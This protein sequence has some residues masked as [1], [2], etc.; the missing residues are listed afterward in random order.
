MFK[1]LFGGGKKDKKKSKV[2]VEEAIQNLD[3][4]IK[5]MELLLNNYE[6][7]TNALQQEAKAKLRAG[8]KA[9]AKRILAKKKR[10]VD[11]IKTT[12]GALMMME[13]Q[14]GMLEN[15]ETVKSTIET[16]KTAGQVIK[17]NQVNVEELD[18]IKDD[19]DE[20]KA[21]GDEIKDFFSDIVDQ[22]EAD[23]EDDLKALEA[24][25]Q[26]DANKELPSAVKTEITG[27]E[28]KNEERDLVPRIDVVIG[29]VH[30]ETGTESEVEAQLKGA[31]PLGFQGQR[32][33]G[34]RQGG[35]Q[36][37]AERPS[38]VGIG[39]LIGLGVAGSL[40]PRGSQFQEV[41]RTPVPVLEGRSRH[42]AQGGRR[43]EV[44][45][46]GDGQRRRPVVASRDVQKHPVAVAQVKEG[47][48]RVHLFF[49]LRLAKDAFRG[50]GVVVDGVEVGVGPSARG[51]VDA[52]AVAVVLL[53]AER[54]THVK[55]GIED[56]I[57]MGGN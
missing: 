32:R 13:E 20:L 24:E 14:K 10:I 51:A 11:Q 54:E 2:N 12:E 30:V 3:K 55:L 43:V 34:G 37:V 41:D 40:C 25:M 31:L 48:Q 5:D 52:V 27:N 36:L 17:E 56:L 7:R 15:A 53:A 50:G 29:E 22:N 42:K 35:R 18:Q 8:D 16:I 26:N 23:V 39:Q 57:F 46:V 6:V 49:P 33:H 4:K 47:I 45:V 28:V 44:A 19:M 21:T 1:N 9:G 38:V